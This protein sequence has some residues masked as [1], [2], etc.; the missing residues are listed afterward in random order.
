M[1]VERYQRQV[2]EGQVPSVFLRSYN[3]GGAGQVGAAWGQVGGELGRWGAWLKERQDKWDAATVMNAQTEFARRMSEW[4]DHPEMGQTVTRKSGAAL[5]L[6]EDTDAYADQAAQEISG[7]LE[8]D[9]QRAVFNSGIAK[10]KL[11]YMRQASTHEAR[12]L[13]AYRKQAFDANLAAANDLYLRGADN[14]DMR[15]QAVDMAANAI[16]SQYFGAPTEYIDRAIAETKSGMA[17]QWVAKVAQDDPRAAMEL[18]KDEELGLLPETADKLRA[19]IKPRAEIYERQAIVDDLVQK[20]PQGMEQEGL[21][22]IREHYEG[23]K[24]ERLA[25][26]YKT[27]MNELDIDENKKRRLRAQAQEDRWV[28]ILKN[29]VDTGMW[30][31]EDEV[32]LMVDNGEI[33]PVRGITMLENKLA[34]QTRA[35]VEKRLAKD[36]KWVTLKP[37]QQEE[38]IMREMDVT[39]AEREGVLAY[40]WNGVL[41]GSVTDAEVDQWFANGRITKAERER[42][43]NADKQMDTAQKNFVKQQREQ[44]KADFKN[45]DIPGK[46]DSLYQ[47]NASLKFNELIKDLNPADKDY[48]KQVLEARKQAFVYGIEQ[49]G[50]ALEKDSNW[51]ALWLNGGQTAFG[52]R[53]EKQMSLIEH[54]IKGVQEYAPKFT[55]D[56]INLPETREAPRRGAKVV[57][58]TSYNEL[59]TVVDNSAKAHGVEPALVRAIIDVESAWNTKAVSSKGAQG[60]MQLMPKTAAGLGVKDAF[61]AEQNIN[62]GTKYIA[63]MLKRYNGD[64]EKALAAYNAGPGHVSVKGKLDFNKLPKPE[65][66]RPYVKNVMALYRKY[67]REAQQAQ[68]PATPQTP[69]SGDITPQGAMSG[70]ITPTRAMSG[71]ITPPGANASRE[72][73]DRYIDS[74]LGGFSLN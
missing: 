21:K 37:E 1:S 73:W 7:M 26:A 66:T 43:K 34:A 65:Q 13:E 38:R 17:A 61:D 62:G 51:Y 18:L 10:A 19:Q 35:Q 30:P 11:P 6:T 8:N 31:S 22:Y 63:D 15:R 68:S 32:R 53:V 56:N 60:L 69:A 40:L 70:D 46:N 24:E 33:S 52:K 4:L 64:V 29:Y 25:S 3:N 27:R 14:P 72:E 12:E 2:A 49:S 36:S 50:K 42:L 55:A 58:K 59:R 28:E 45:A 39:K 57:G 48:R 44:L 67:Q 54:Q 47:T 9:Q 16:R 23:E 5:H 41:D 20:Y 74:K 71:D